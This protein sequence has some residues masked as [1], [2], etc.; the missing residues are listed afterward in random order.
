M[1]Q[2]LK[3]VYR[4]EGMKRD[5]A[6]YVARC[7]TCQLVKAE[8]QKPFGKLNPLEIPPVEMGS[9]HHGLR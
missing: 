4:W 6:D 1:Y 8:H 2:D 9:H 3:R 7:H 5:V